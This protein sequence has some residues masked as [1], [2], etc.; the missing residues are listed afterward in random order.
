MIIWP[1]VSLA[2]LL[3]LSSLFSS[4]ETAYTS[5]SQWQI[6]A[7]AENYGRRGLMVKKLTERPEIL[8]TTLLIGNN[9]ANLGAS[10]LTTAI[11]IEFIGNTFVAVT[12]GVL[13]FIVLV[14]CEVSPKQ[15]AL[16]INEKLCLRSAGSIMILAW[17]LRPII[18][19]IGAI[20]R[21][22]THLFAGQ[23]RKSLSLEMLL[24]HVKAAGHEGIVE[25]YEEK[26]VRNVF[27]INDTPVEAIMTH[28]TDLFT[29]NEET[30]VEQALDGF[31]KTGYSH[32]P[33]LR[34]DSEHVSGIVSFTD[35][36]AAVKNNPSSSVKHIASP[37]KL[38][39]G[40]MK[41]HEFFFQLKKESVHLAV[42]LDE[43]GGLD[44]VVTREDVIEEIFGDLYDE[45]ETH[46]ADPIST[47]GDGYWI[48][49]GDTDFYD[50]SDVLGLELEHDNRTHTLGGYL[51]EKLGKIPEPG[52][53]IELPEGRYDILKTFRNRISSVRFQPKQTSI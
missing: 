16:A 53:V 4:L 34:G 2:V 15:I 39:P 17:L 10:A 7:L 3:L 11:T 26:M 20:S 5:L 28:R 14:F 24:H 48:I 36:A 22:I 43:Y 23:A 41:A 1:A 40:T 30:S 31:M 52:T 49:Q 27:R 12:T 9:L 29:V 47:D 32:A 25:S 46:A 19:L 45:G 44:G 38:V 18:W 35:A 51:L 21:S 37:P 6:N 42:V 8:L 13:T 33:V 50:I